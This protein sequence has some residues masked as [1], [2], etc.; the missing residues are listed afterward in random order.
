MRETF[1]KNIK[2]L[3]I[4]ILTFLIYKLINEK[5]LITNI[6]SITIS[7][8]IPFIWAVVIAYILNPLLNIF[9]KKKKFSRTVSIILTYIVALLLIL[10]LLL[11]IIPSLMESITD[12]ISESSYY[13]TRITTWYE[14][15]LSSIES[16]KEFTDI[17]NIDIEEITIGKIKKEMSELTNNLQSY[18]MTFG[19]LVFNFTSGFLHFLIGFVVSI[20][21]LRD[22]EKFSVGL[23]RLSRSIFGDERTKEIHRVFAII[24]EVFSNYIIG[25]SLDS[26]IIGIICFLGLLILRVKYAVLFSVI[27]GVSNMIPYFGPF[28]GA[29]P[30]VIITLLIDPFKAVAVVIFIFILQQLDGY[31][32]GPKIIGNSVGIS[33]FW[34]ILSIVIGGQLF[35]VIGMLIGVPVITVAR[36]LSLAKIDKVLSERERQIDKEKCTD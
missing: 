16:V 24:D 28:I 1:K 33:S 2:Y 7:M 17:Y 23:T 15:K 32:I 19:R 13:G 14:N 21:F 29:V 9:E 20:Y 34:V 3:P 35:G 22:K 4:V 36:Q 11:I 6:V 10:G 12:I 31:V 8:F 18:I 27:V 30:A 5:G 26:L 25:K